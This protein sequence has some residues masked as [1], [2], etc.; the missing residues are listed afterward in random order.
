MRSEPDIERGTRTEGIQSVK[1]ATIW[2]TGLSGSGKSTIA[3]AL[4]RE[5]FPIEESSSA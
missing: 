4:V 5:T 2:F 3:E 1:P